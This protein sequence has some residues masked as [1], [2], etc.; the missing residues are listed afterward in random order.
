MTVAT[1]R[2]ALVS[3]PLVAALAVCTSGIGASAAFAQGTVQLRPPAP[4]TAV[5]DPASLPRVR[6]GLIVRP[7]SVQVGDP[8]TLV[9]TVMVPASA[10]I[11]W[12]VIEDTAAVVGMRAPVSV[13]SA[14]DG[15]MRRETA[16]YALAAW[17]VGSLALGVPDPTVRYGTTTLRVPIDSARVYV[18]SVLP[19]DSTMHLPKPSKGLFSR[20]IPWWERWWPAAAVVVGLL[21]LWWLFRRRKR[22][23]VRR[24]V[25][26]LDV[27]ARAMHDFERLDRLS[28]TDAGE[29]GRAVALAVEILRSYLGA[30][31]PEAGLSLTST[32]LLDATN[33]DA[34]VP[35]ERLFYL[36]DDADAIKFARRVVNG[37]R[38]KALTA[39]SRAIVE[40]IESVEQERV[41]AEAERRVREAKANDDA[42][43]RDED[44]ARRK[45]RRKAGAA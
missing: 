17:D 23:P 27:Y 9:V 37:A 22:A 12:P 39:E 33:L 31:V 43:Q 24:A 19:G 40:S 6:S 36:L 30:R 5:T 18:R 26:P 42:R 10:R 2:R 38:A 20:E 45:S 4:G 8:F 11:E 14:S 35:H 44:D 32:E 29:R 3:L 28:L 21:L 25:V 7:D 15:P 16:T 13:T 1:A 34:R 41:K